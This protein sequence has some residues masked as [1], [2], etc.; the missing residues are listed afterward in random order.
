M[1]SN[2]CRRPL[3]PRRAL[4]TIVSALL[5]SNT[6]AAATRTVTNL[7]DNG[8]GSLRRAL[9]DAAAGDTIA[10]S[11][12]GT[13]V[14]TG[15]E[16][17]VGTSDL[18]IQGPGAKL[19]A[20][21]G[22]DSHRIFNVLQGARVAISG[23]TL[24]DGNVTSGGAAILNGGN[25][26]LT[27]CTISNNR[28]G[29]IRNAGTMEV[30]RCT[31]SANV[32]QNPV[33]GNAVGG[34]ILNDGALTISNSTVADNEVVDDAL[35]NI[36]DIAQGA[37]IFAS[38]GSQ[39][40]TVSGCTISGN[41]VT[42]NG[43]GLKRGAGIANSSSDLANVRDTIVAGNVAPEKP[44]VDGRF[45]SGGYNLIGNKARAGDIDNGVGFDDGVNNDQVGGAGRPPI[46]PRLG[47]LAD[48]GGPTFTKALLSGSPAIDQGI[49]D[50]DT[51]QRG[52][53]RRFDFAEKPNAEGGDASDVGAFELG[54]MTSGPAASRL[55]NVSTR[56]RVQPG[57]RQLI[58]GFIVTGDP[59][60]DVVLR[61][62]GPSLS[63]AGLSNVLPDPR[64]QLAAPDGTLLAE[65]NNWKD[66]PEQ[67]AQLQAQGLAP[68]DD[69]E[70]AIVTTLAAGAYTAIVSGTNGESGL[71]LVEAYDVNDGVTSQLGN[72][73]TR[74]SVETGDNV[75]IG[76]FI[77]GGGDAEARVVVRAIGPTLSQSGVSGPLQDPTLELR[78]ADGTL[79]RG[80]D[81]WK[82][83]QQS[84]IEATG[85][86]P[87]NDLESAVVAS[88]PPG[89]YTAI[90]RGKDETSGVGLV[91][92]YNVP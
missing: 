16:L 79:I 63:K 73:S 91:E 61:A 81:N 42:G 53:A 41:R 87:A 24:R 71:G 40:L 77:V 20:V 44:D 84:A 72:I 15:S 75:L 85:L 49:S 5:L 80:N 83:S 32:V 68:E 36:Q 31:I 33:G 26:S 60:K 48:N 59:P 13:I 78:A 92:I 30:N 46:D 25:V 6:A 37:G 45:T 90:V 54:A 22:N 57:E 50:L 34:G 4:A 39:S 11:V 64:L 52:A 3:N 8:P 56:A 76:G 7:D 88:L 58:G 74:A 9:A 65:N 10:F 19:L 17:E 2:L 12:T 43:L 51:D 38:F 28:G 89:N 35:S 69:R 82:E 66:N 67:G 55:R 86:Q 70:S 23:I 27:E 21:S 18:K 1:R 29:G 14:L 47:P 62:I